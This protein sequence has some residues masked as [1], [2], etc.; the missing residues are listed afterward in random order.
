MTLLSNLLFYNK[1]NADIFYIKEDNLSK[2]KGL[3]LVPLERYSYKTEGFE[4]NVTIEYNIKYGSNC[5]GV[6]MF[7]Q[8]SG[9]CID[10]DGKD[11]TG[12]NLFFANPQ[13]IFFKP[14]MLALA[15]NWS[16]S[17]GYAD[18]QTGTFYSEYRFRVVGEEKIFGRDSF[19]VEIIGP[20]LNSKQWIDKQKR[21]LLKEETD[22]YT[23]IIVDAPFA[24]LNLSQN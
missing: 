13:I 15:P 20:E 12:S 5:M 22:S 14:W 10:P 6:Y 3:T 9:I 23:I 2:N 21:V 16:W 24:L 18:K 8:Y 17:A 4:E 1:F 19:I 7:E 11:S